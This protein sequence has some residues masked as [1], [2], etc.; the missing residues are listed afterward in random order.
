ML[1]LPDGLIG[2]NPKYPAIVNHDWLSVDPKTYDNYPSDNN[3]VRIVPKLAELWDHVNQGNPT[4]INLIPNQTVQQ[5]GVNSSGVKSEEAA[6]SVIREAKK[7]MMSGLNG[8]DL[9]DHLRARFSSQDIVLAKDGLSKLS[10][11]QGL[12]GNVYIDASAFSSSKD[13]ERFLTQHRTRLA[14][15]IVLNES[16]INPLVIGVL[17]SKFRK[18]VLAMVSYDEKTFEKYKAHLVASDRIPKDF[19]INSKETLRQAFLYQPVKETIVKAKTEKPVDKAMM[20]KNLTDKV[21]KEALDS[22]LANDDISFRMAYPILKFAREQMTKGKFGNDL[23][24][25]LRKKYAAVD[26]KDSAKYMTMIISDQ[27]TPDN[28]DEMVKVNAIS[29]YV[30]NNLKK[31]AKDY[32]VKKTMFAEEQ[33][34][35]KSIGVQGYF[36]NLSGSKV[37]DD[38]DQYREACVTA[39]RKGV[40]LDKIRVKLASLKLSNDQINKVLSD[41]MNMFNSVA[42]GVK[43]NPQEKKAKVKVVADLPERQTLP[44]PDTIV[45]QSQDIIS[46]FEGSG[47]EIDIDLAPSIE[48]SLDIGGLFNRSG[49]DSVL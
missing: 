48:P 36:Y 29:E 2:T 24:E 46:F 49:M 10:E 40:E 18:N 39:L 1:D 38:F 47:D 11:E 6:A 41:A 27:L 8:K 30:G 5:L 28:I 19:V 23:K 35:P 33:K 3:P 16:K 21:T 20:L 22:Q 43:A 32:P 4:G 14:Q 17:A 34:A 13:A 9:A 37:S 15:D 12:L 45:P 7:A 25:M 31:L 26:L 44:N 42:A